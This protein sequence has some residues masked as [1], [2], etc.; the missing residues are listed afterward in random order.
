MSGISSWDPGPNSFART[1]RSFPRAN[2]GTDVLPDET[3]AILSDKNVAIDVTFKSAPSTVVSG[4]PLRQG[5]PLYGEF[6]QIRVAPN[7]N[8]AK[9]FI[10]I[11]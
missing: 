8:S 10:G 1:W 5:V 11:R 4:I 3:I 9:Y 7:T 2:A 6:H